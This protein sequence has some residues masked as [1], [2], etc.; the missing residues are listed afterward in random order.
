MKSIVTSVSATRNGNQFW[1]AIFWALGVLSEPS[2]SAFS[3]S[4]AQ[5]ARHWLIYRRFQFHLARLADTQVAFLGFPEIRRAQNLI[6]D[7]LRKCSMSLII[8]VNMEPFS[9]SI[10]I[11][12][13][14][15]C[16]T[17]TRRAQTRPKGRSNTIFWQG[18]AS[19]TK[20]FDWLWPRK[21]QNFYPPKTFDWL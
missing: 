7:D 10:F 16:N 5:K 6:F 18:L 13:L 8:L 21:C 11:P 1:D 9:S 4:L 19:W 3:I 17:T 12:S 2:S 15:N 14:T 20:T